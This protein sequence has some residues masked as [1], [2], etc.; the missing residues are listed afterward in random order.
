MHRFAVLLSTVLLL[1]G[2]SASIAEEVEEEGLARLKEKPFRESYRDEAPVS[3]RVVAGVIAGSS[4][5]P[6]LA[7]LPPASASGKSVCVQVMS[8][9]GRYS[10]K[11]TFLIPSGVDSSGFEL[12]YP[13]AHES[14]LFELDVDALA[15][16]T[17]PGDCTDSTASTL[18]L[19]T[20]RPEREPGS[21][22]VPIRIFVNSARADTFVAVKNDPKGKRPTRCQEIEEGRRTGFDKICSIEL[23]GLDSSLDELEVRILRRQYERMLPPTEFTLALPPA[24]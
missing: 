18:Y 17:S 6:G 23:S 1:G 10:S 22:P 5:Q 14:F 8:R 21:E 11:N 19:S 9:D 4:G 7:L 2:A 13:S 16:L 3:G 24:P 20:T 12:E 15:I